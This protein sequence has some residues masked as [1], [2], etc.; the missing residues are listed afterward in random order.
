MKAKLNLIAAASL[1]VLLAACGGGGGGGDEGGGGSVTQ[2]TPTPATSIPIQTSVP[3]ATYSAAEGLDQA[4]AILNEGL[5]RCG[6]G[7][8]KQSAQLDAAAANHAN[9]I[10]NN[11]SSYVPHKETPGATGFTGVEYWDRHDAAGYTGQS[12][13]EVEMVGY[14][15]Y[16]T[17]LANP[18]TQQQQRDVASWSV[19]NFFIAPY[20]GMNMLKGAV[21]VGMAAPVSVSMNGGLEKFIKPVVITLG[22]GS[23]VDG[24]Q[25]SDPDAIRTFPC[26][27]LADVAPALYGE[28]VPN[29]ELAPGRNLN[30]NPIGTT[31][32]VAAMP[33]KT[34]T[35]TSANILEIST[36]QN[37]P[38]YAIRNYADDPNQHVHP[39]PRFAYVMPDRALLP[40]TQ[41][42]V[43]VS[44]N[45]D[46]K[47]FTRTFQFRT[48]VDIGASPVEVSMKN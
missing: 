42:Q 24:Q 44:G 31:I 8:I 9:Y 34:A 29:G 5:S 37:V 38:V 46:G 6:F 17:A 18:P 36:G 2:P 35:I 23:A 22:A 3:A 39:G 48:G 20:H 21:E 30:S 15:A 11:F 1:S 28:Y 40:N 19:K 27:G 10:L 4:Y 16:N 32:Y 45:V 43:M 12:V 14:L 47:L 7:A 26:D 41:Y 33:G 13:G 25:P